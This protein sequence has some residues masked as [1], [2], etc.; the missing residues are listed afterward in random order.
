MWIE[1]KCDQEKVVSGVAIEG[2]EPINRYGVVWL[3]RNFFDFIQH[4]EYPKWQSL[5][6]SWK[7]LCFV[8]KQLPEAT[9]P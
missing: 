1:L 4:L 5:D 9:R 8:Y 6:Q 7:L 2:R 3:L